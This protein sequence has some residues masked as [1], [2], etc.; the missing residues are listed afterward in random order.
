MVVILDDWNTS[1]TDRQY[2]AKPQSA[3][4]RHLGIGVMAPPSAESVCGWGYPSQERE[5]Q[6][7]VTGVV[8]NGKAVATAHCPNANSG[9][10][11]KSP[12]CGQMG[13]KCIRT[14]GQARADFALTM[15]A[16]TYN[17]K[18]LVFLEAD[19]IRALACP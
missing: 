18:R 9:I 14:I 3:Y 11:I 4:W 8:S 19:P 5:E 17:I 15:M 13:G 1:A 12:K 6:P 7:K 2:G 10:T 16:V